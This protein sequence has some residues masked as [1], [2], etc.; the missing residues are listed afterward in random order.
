VRTQVLECARSDI[1]AIFET[2]QCDPRHK[3]VTIMH[4]HAVEQRC[5]GDWSMAFAG[6]DGVSNDPQILADGM[7]PTDGILATPARKSL[8]AALHSVVHRNDV[9]RREEIVAP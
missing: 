2:I 5:F 4:L 9:A 1:E 8:L 3:D 6:I 7:G